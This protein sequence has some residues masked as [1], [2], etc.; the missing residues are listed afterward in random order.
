MVSSETNTG[1]WSTA[2]DGE[3]FPNIVALDAFYEP[4][5]NDLANGE[6][7]LTL[8]STNSALCSENSS[9]LTI[10]FQP[11]PVADAG[12]NHVVCGD[13]EQVQ[14]LGNVSGATGGVWSTAGSGTFFPN[15]SVL[16]ALYTPSSADSLNG[17]VALTLTTY[18]NGECAGDMDQMQIL[19][20]GAVAAL[21]GPDQ[22]VCENSDVIDLVGAVEESD[23]YEWGTMGTGSFAPSSANLTTTYL[24]FGGGQDPGK[25]NTLPHGSR[26]R[27]LSF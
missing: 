11:L 19:F 20:S 6:V 22:D 25:C 17:S 3:F 4:G 10:E 2:G 14:L 1:V 13:L 26:N 8:T 12:A 24:A 7:D 9:T 16:T 5:P 18:G 27:K 21:A 23:A 15:D